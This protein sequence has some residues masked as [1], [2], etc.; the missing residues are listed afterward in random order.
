MRD[1][2]ITN[3]AVIASVIAAAELLLTAALFAAFAK[4]QQPAILLAALIALGLTFDAAVMALGRV[5]S[6]DILPVLSRIRFVSHGLLVP[7]N[8]AVCGYALRWEHTKKMTVIW[9]IT[10]IVCLLGAA[11][12]FARVLELRDF[13]GMLRHVAGDST[14]LWADKINRVLSFGTVLPLIAAGVAVIIREKNPSIFLAGLLMFVF[15][16]VGPATGNADLIFLI[17]MI[18]ELLMAV[19][20]LCFALT[21]YRSNDE[22]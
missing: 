16:A 4:K 15:A 14:P 19:F 8:I 2:F 20:F 10:A 11:S 3:G 12:G 18:G 21:A 6:P 13:A 22:I 7:L 17:S 5:I 9:V 1:F